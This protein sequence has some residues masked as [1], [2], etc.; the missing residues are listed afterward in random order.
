[1]KMPV[2]R[3]CP[4][5][6]LIISIAVF[7]LPFSLLSAGVRKPAA[8][9]ESGSILQVKYLGGDNDALFFDVKYYNKTGNIFKLLVL[10]EITGDA[11]FQDNYSARDFEKK[12]KIP[13]LTDTDYVTFLI[14]S[15]K[16]NIL[17][18]YK[19]K[20]TTKVVDETVFLKNRELVSY[21]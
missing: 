1:M 7:F 10:D 11:L 3:I 12:F 18:S 2:I 19:V 20:V 14:R 6:A 8:G 17:L 13:R 16:E 9:G 5:K 21:K 4:I 15:A